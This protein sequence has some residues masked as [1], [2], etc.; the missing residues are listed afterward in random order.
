MRHCG[1]L[2]DP[3]EV[4]LHDH[5]A[6]FG[7]SQRD[8]LRVAG[9]VLGEGLRADRRE[10]LVLVADGPSADGL[11]LPGLTSL[12]A[13]G[14]LR[15]FDTSALYRESRVDPYETLSAVR[16]MLREALRD[17]YSGVRIVA[18]NTGLA[19]AMGAKGWLAWEELADREQ[20]HQPIAGVCYFDTSRLDSEILAELAALH[21]LANVDSYSPGFQ[22][23]YDAEARR[24]VGEVDGFNSDQLV[25]CLSSSVVPGRRVLDLS[26]LEFI[27]HHGL[28][29]LQQSLPPEVSL[30]LVGARPAVRRLG[31]LL[32][33][34]Q[35]RVELS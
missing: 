8:F 28:L 11:E 7:S 9:A 17:G 2:D 22:L 15:I 13:D 35:E 16:E 5:V 12:L 6:W 4:R 29:A 32:G 14:V 19:E 20:A 33:L 18:D 25:S 26:G 21:P 10:R 3:A 31:G 24:L 1:V 23:F 34:D 27:D 30:T